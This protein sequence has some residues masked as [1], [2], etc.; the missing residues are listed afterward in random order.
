MRHVTEDEPERALA[1]IE[2]ALAP[3]PQ[4]PFTTNHFGAFQS[5]AYILAGCEQGPQFMQF[6]AQRR[7]Q[8]E[9]AFLMRMVA[10]GLLWRVVRLQAILQTIEAPRSAEGLRLRKLAQ[11]ELRAIRRVPGRMAEGSALAGDA[12]LYWVDG[13]RERALACVRRA[14]QV[15]S[16]M[17]HFAIPALHYVYGLMEGGESGRQRCS[18]ARAKVEAEGWKSWRRGLAMGVYGNLRLLE[19]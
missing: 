12:W 5:S 2:A 17:E 15:L 8:I 10:P 16:D 7:P 9:G 14:T 6:L 3:W 18:E 4:E 13:E 19:G 1:E 11:V